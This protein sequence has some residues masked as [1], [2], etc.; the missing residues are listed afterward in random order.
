M[1]TVGAVAAISTN[2]T[3]T[4]CMCHLHVVVSYARH[5]GGK[6]IATQSD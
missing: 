6:D 1:S 5:D 2:I 4:A 3:I